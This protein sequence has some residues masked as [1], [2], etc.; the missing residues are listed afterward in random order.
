MTAKEVREYRNVAKKLIEVE[1]KAKLF[2][3]LRK[4][5]VN[6]PEEE[7]QVQKNFSKF[8]VLGNKKGILAQKHEEIMSLSLNLKIKDNNLYGRKLRRKKNWLKGKLEDS[9]GK[10]SAEWRSLEEDVRSFGSKH[11]RNLKEKYRKKTEHLVKKFGD[12]SK[13]SIR[14]DEVGKD[15]RDIMGTPAIFAMEGESK[16]EDIK[17]PVIVLGPGE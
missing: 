8:K 5:G 16:I 11:R 17:D 12:Q 3:V 10:K 7:Y 2:Q 9:M 1:E 6:L 15:V 14:W 4:K 13:S